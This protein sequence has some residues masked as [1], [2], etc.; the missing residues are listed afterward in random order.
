M[1]QELKPFWRRYFTYDWRFGLFLLLIICVPRFWMVLQANK[2]GNYQY[3]G[4]I[5]VLSALAPFVF[6]TR[7]GRKHIGLTKPVS[8]AWP[9]TGLIAGGAAALLLHWLGMF[10]YGS[11]MENWYG[12]IA[13]SYNIPASISA[14][15]KL[16]LFLVI[17]I[18]GMIFSPIGEELFFRGIVHGSLARSIGERR[19]SITDSAAFAITHLSHFGIVYVSGAWQLLPVPALVWVT[20]MFLVSLLFLFFKKRTGSL[21]GAI[22]CH[23]GFNLGMTYAI[24]YLF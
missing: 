23:A 17:A 19:A 2:T 20:G 21:L 8:F 6:L 12:Y 9:I 7:F 16:T 3:I 15:E 11:G 13:R 22:L 4:L 1:Q 10:L 24:F 14:S 5:M 18:T